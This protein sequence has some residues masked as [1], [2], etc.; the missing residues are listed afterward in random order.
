MRLAQRLQVRK[1]RERPLSGF[2]H[3]TQVWG[4]ESICCLRESVLAWVDGD[5]G[6]LGDGVGVFF[7]FFFSQRGCCLRWRMTN[8]SD[9]T[10]GG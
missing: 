6:E 8:L 7:I 4:V 10:V 3:L 2:E 1:G 9:W 5:G